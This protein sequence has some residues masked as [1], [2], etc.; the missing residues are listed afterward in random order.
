VEGCE[1]CDDG[2]AE[3]VADEEEGREFGPGE[4]G[5]G[6]EQGGEGVV[7]EGFERVV[8][9]RVV[10]FGGFGGDGGAVAAG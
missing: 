6:G 10:G 9:G 5:L 2:A 8:C 7:C 4:V 1:V 3:G